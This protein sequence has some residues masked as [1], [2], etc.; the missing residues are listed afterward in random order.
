[1]QYITVIM[2]YGI[3]PVLFEYIFPEAARIFR[4]P[5]L[6]GMKQQVYHK[7]L[8]IETNHF[9]LAVL[10]KN[11]HEQIIVPVITKNENLISSLRE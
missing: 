5:Q 10:S 8:H 3:K 7:F 9:N 4:S 1:M 11:L 6:E 2:I